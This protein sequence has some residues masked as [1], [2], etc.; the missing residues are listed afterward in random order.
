MLAVYAA[1][2]VSGAAH[3]GVDHAWPLHA[4]CPHSLED[5]HHTLC[6]Q[7]VQQVGNGNVGASSTTPTAAQRGPELLKMTRVSCDVSHR[8]TQR[9]SNV[10]PKYPSILSSIIV[11][12]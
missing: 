7:P 8:C 3:Q 5:V 10:T 2:I 1:F 9:D 12:S 11:V 4:Q 6:L